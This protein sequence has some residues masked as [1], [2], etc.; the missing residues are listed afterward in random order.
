MESLSKRA[1]EMGL[2]MTIEMAKKARELSATGKNVISLSL[3]E[4][5]FDTPEFI[6]DA[7]SQAMVENYTHYMPVPGFSD[8][9][10]SIAAKFKR[11]NGIEYTADQIVIST[12]AKQSLLNI[13]LALVNPG[14]E[15]IIPAPYWV[16]YMDQAVYCGA[17]VKVLPTTM[18]SGFKITAAQLESAITPKS[19]VL[20]F[21]S[22]NNP[23]GAVYSKEDLAAIAAVVAK[24]PNLYIISDE[25]YELLN[26]GE[27]S[28][29]SI[30]SFPEVY[31][32]TITVNG[33]SKGFAMT[34]WRIGY[35]GAPEWIAK[36]CTKFQSNFTSGANSIAQRAC[37]AAVESDPSKVNYMVEKFAYRREKM[38]TW[39]KE[40]PG[41][42]LETPPGAFYV[43][44][45][46]TALLGKKFNGQVL[47]TALDVSMYLLEEGLV[48]TVPGD[49]FGLPGYIR[50]SYAAAEAELEEAVKR[51]KVAVANLED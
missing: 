21:S 28:H 12:G 35:I 20:I 50:F 26:Y 38:V 24:H 1:Q 8:V 36:A 42:E 49:A 31:N 40:I 23:C 46:I 4:P 37:K 45:R 18:E 15:V 47:E 6:K 51:V 7:A 13:F 43:F 22:P 39:M 44:P 10:E 3:G 14:E 25:I 41:F 33:L 19:K 17:D 16:S 29:V 34:G 32:Q 27:V 30:A 9:R 11:D 5:D 2:P 48:S